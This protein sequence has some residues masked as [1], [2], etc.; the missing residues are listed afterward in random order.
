MDV[1]EPVIIV[2]VRVQ[3]ALLA[4]RVTIPWK[5]SRPVIVS[6]EVACSLTPAFRLEGLAEIPK[7]WTV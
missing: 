5:K 7:S 3:A 4:V 6:V 2:G 1:P